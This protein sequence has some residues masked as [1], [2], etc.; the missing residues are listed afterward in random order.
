MHTPKS[1]SSDRP[2][3][4]LRLGTKSCAECRRRKVRCI[5]EPNTKI[6][7]ECAAHES[8]CIS[9]QS[10]HASKQSPK[11]EG[12]DIQAKLQ[13]LEQM[14]HRLCEAVNVR[15]ESSASSPFE[16]SAAEALTRLQSS[17]STETSLVNTPNMGA[18]WREVSES[19]SS[20]SSEQIESFDDAPLLNLFQE[21]MLIQKHRGW[22]QQNNQELSSDYRTKTYIKAIKALIPNAA[23]LELVLQTTE[24]FW[25]IW[26]DSLDLIIGPEPHSITSLA[27]A[28]QFIYESTKSETPML[29]AKSALFLALCVQQLPVSFKNRATNLPASPQA[30]VDSYMSGADGLIS[31]NENRSPTIDSLECLNILL[32][33]YINNGKPREAW[34]CVRRA[35]NSALLLGLHNLDDTAPYR[36][37]A[38]WAHIWQFER[39]LS[40]LLGLPSATTASHPGVSTSPPEQDIGARVMYEISTIAG[41]IIERNQNHQMANYAVTL[42]ID[43]EI[44]QC[45][46]RLPSEWWNSPP[47]T[48]MPLAAIYGVGVLKIEFYA[49]QKMLH[50]PYML[51]SSP[52]NNYEYSRLQVLD[53]CR[54]MIKAY[55]IVRQH[56]QLNLTIC[57]LMD[58]QAFTAAVVIIIDLLNQSSQLETHQEASD[59][60]LV[61]D[62]KRSL[63]LVS[64]AMECTVAG[65]GFYLLE[66]L[67][68]F[69]NGAYAGPDNY[70][71]TIPMFGRVKI[72]RPK[73]RKVQP[74]FNN[75]YESENQFQ[76]QF[77]PTLEFSANTFAPFGMT[78]D[79]MSDAELGIDWTS[80][81]NMDYNYDWNQ[82]FDGSLFG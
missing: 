2:S 53:A 68:S 21:A 71:V 23:D 77:F 15:S 22:S 16:M 29:I 11:E 41:R 72:S 43:Q 35:L 65:Q 1:I 49:G 5:F 26:E 76:P 75:F 9:Q 57:D 40:A 51:K 80:A 20:A 81:L 66:H 47:T 10:V 50:L 12:Q 44:Q 6:C 61:H 38:V 54:E 32:K 56:P 25:P 39:H 45:K 27:T 46:S 73:S 64:V 30:L 14:V 33:L 59:W 8:E 18:G 58:F 42:A 78:G 67:A 37:K 52:D 28:K 79:V 70:D 13:G 36:E 7:K 19:R 34:H 62:V 82:T 55:Q 24:P 48:S 74:E 17:S 69:R 3:K 31:I 63:K 4:R 60:N